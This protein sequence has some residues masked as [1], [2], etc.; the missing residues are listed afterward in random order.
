S[1]QKLAEAAV[2]Q[3]APP[4]V[5]TLLDVD[6]MELEVG[7]GL[8][9]LVDESSG[10][11]LLERVSM[12]RRQL[13][14]ELG[15][16]VPPVRIRDN[17]QLEANDYVVK[18]RGMSVARG[19]VFPDQYLAMDSGAATSPIPHATQTTEPAFG[20]PAYWI[21]EPQKPEAEVLNYTVVEASAVLATHLT[22][23]VK[24][25]AGDLLSRQETRNLLDHLKAKSPALVEE[26]VPELVKPGDLQKVLQGLLKERVPIR[27]LE[28]ILETL[29]DYSSRTK[30]LDVLG[31]YCR[32]AL[33]RTICKMHVDDSDTLYCVT[34]DP[35]MEDVINSNLQ[36]TESGTTNTMP[37]QTVQ[38]TVQKIAEKVS[39][40]TAT[41]RPAV[42]VCSPSV[43]LAVRRIIEPTLPQVA[44]LG[45]NEIVPE[46]K[47]EAV[48]L[49]SLAA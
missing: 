41:G 46:V 23:V 24:Q 15:L 27:D 30:D 49:V 38:A 45:Y 1:R 6:A 34:L 37:P 28:T 12:I 20:L 32:N 39:E 14:S 4:A 11:D 47:V 26:A 36:R 25:H 7:F 35:A 17:M 21:T 43:R 9:K 3:E 29:S 19:E 16:I 33:A 40:L 42:V 48:G 22:E 10:G 18:I 44:V 13:A 2:E 31:E 8:V 5:E